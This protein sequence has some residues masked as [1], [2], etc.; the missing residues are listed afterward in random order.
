MID[1]TIE[2]K[3][4]QQRAKWESFMSRIKIS[5]FLGASVCRFWILVKDSQWICSATNET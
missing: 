5:T 4:Q 1:I 3:T 2:L